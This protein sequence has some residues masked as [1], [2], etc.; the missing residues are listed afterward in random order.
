MQPRQLPDGLLEVLLRGRK[1]FVPFVLELATYP[2]KRLVR[3]LVRSAMLVYLDRE[4]LPE[5]IAVILRPKG[6]QPIPTE[7]EVVSPLVGSRCRLQ[8]RVVKLWEVPSADLLKSD[9]VGL[10]PWVPLTDFSD[11]PRRIIEECRRR[12]D[13]EAPE[14]ER[15]NLL[16]VTQVLTRLRYNSERLFQILGGGDA[17]LELPFLDELVSKK[18]QIN[19][20]LDVLES[21]FDSRPGDFAEKLRALG[22]EDLKALIRF[23]A[24]CPD[25]EGFRARVQESK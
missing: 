18:T 24:V 21:R 5:I 20:I 6:R 1:K 7:T 25:L 16:A 2:E 11:P 19:A 3:Q 13:A 17:M 23:A 10:V 12:I 14:N 15:Q 9:D 8:W 22:E 4:T